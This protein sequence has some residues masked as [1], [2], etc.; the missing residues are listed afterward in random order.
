MGLVDPFD[1]ERLG[2]SRI[3]RSGGQR[4]M[5]DEQVEQREVVFIARTGS[6][7]LR[8]IGYTRPICSIQRELSVEGIHPIA[9][10][11]RAVEAHG[12]L[13]SLP[14]ERE[15]IVFR[16]EDLLVFAA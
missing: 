13:C 16:L 4:R 15:R 5:F 3:Q 6:D 10:L 9:K 7:C 8:E 11:A 12:N 14:I 1:T 2:E